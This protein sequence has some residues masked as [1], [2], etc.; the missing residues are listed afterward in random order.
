MPPFSAC[1]KHVCTSPGACVR[2]RAARPFTPPVAPALASFP[3]PVV[4]ALIA[5]LKRRSSRQLSANLS[6]SG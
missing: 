5:G 1:V 2:T 6:G 4:A 3:L